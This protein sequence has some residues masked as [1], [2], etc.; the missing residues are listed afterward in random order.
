VRRL[1]GAE[2]RDFAEF[3]REHAG[4]FGAAERTLI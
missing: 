3:A 2:P 1:T 4:A